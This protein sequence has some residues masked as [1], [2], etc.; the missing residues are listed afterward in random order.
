MNASKRP[1]LFLL[2]FVSG[3]CGLVYQVIW[4]RMAFA[5]FGII[6]PV[7]SVVISVFMLGLALGSW[8]GGHWV[9]GFS[10]QLRL[11]PIAL[12]AAAEA[13]IGLGAFA[14]PKLF[15]SG[16]RVL[17]GVG[18]TDS[19]TY[20]I[21]SG[22]VLALSIFPWCFCM[23]T[24]FPFMMAYVRQREGES[25]ESFSYLYLA[26]VPGAMA[27]ALVTALAFV[28]LFGFNDTLR[29]A[30]SGNFLVALVSLWI[31]R[32]HLRVS[33]G[34]HSPNLENAP[35]SPSQP[36][37]G[38]D[39][40]PLRG[41]AIQWLLFTT[42]FSS[43][44]M[45]VVWTRYFAPVLRRRF[46]RLRWSWRLT[47]RL[48]LLVRCSIA[49]SC[50]RIS[51]AARS[52]LVS[53]LCAAAFLPV[54]ANDPHFV[55]TVWYEPYPHMRQRSACAGKHPALLRDARVPHSLPD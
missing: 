53:L 19:M 41:R 39:T 13:L 48:L 6:T 25:K 16:E 4:T 18:Q 43:M 47:W 14:V 7:L 50:G 34:T 49:G 9:E 29:V 37:T 17:L 54:F 5:S 36:A 24:T 30:A 51:G 27:G 45:E 38:S 3:F 12:Y 33:T 11:S 26:N 40:G 1:I 46:T 44:A 32:E 35:V 22:V 8:A 15:A 23:G 28:E 52:C 31:A 20:W 2:F 42:G 10:R 21:L 55:K